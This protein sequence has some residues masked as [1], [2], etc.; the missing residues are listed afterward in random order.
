MGCRKPTTRTTR[1]WATRS[2]H[3]SHP[4]AIPHSHLRVTHHNKVQHPV[5]H[6]N[7]EVHQATRNNLLTH[8]KATRTHTT[9]LHANSPPLQSDW[10]MTT[11][12]TWIPNMNNKN[13]RFS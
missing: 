7:R 12:Q 1:T 3:S 5:T 8:S 13:G 9:L 11:L 10:M 4:R 6:L 2:T